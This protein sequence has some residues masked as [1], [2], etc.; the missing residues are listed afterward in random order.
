M[1]IIPQQ[2]VGRTN[3][4][5]SWLS[6]IIAKLRNAIETPPGYQD[7]TGFYFGVVSAEKEVQWPP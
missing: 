6:R 2:I 5:L 7:E 4:A 1:Q 3:A